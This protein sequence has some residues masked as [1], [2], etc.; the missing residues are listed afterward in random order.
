[1]LAAQML[2]SP[3]LMKPQY[4]TGVSKKTMLLA[5]ILIYFTMYDI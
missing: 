1:M 4:N 5:A 3:L 2:V